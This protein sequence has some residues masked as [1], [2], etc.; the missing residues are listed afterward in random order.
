MHQLIVLESNPKENEQ[1]PTEIDGLAVDIPQYDVRYVVNSLESKHVMKYKVFVE[2]KNKEQKRFIQDNSPKKIKHEINAELAE[3][4][5]RNLA[6]RVQ[7][8]PDPYYYYDPIS[9]TINAKRSLKKAKKIH[10]KFKQQ[11]L[12]KE[13]K[14][15]EQVSPTLAAIPLVGNYYGFHLATAVQKKSADLLGTYKG[16][17]DELNGL[18][19]LLHVPEK[20]EKEVMENN[21]D[22]D[23]EDNANEETDKDYEDEDNKENQKNKNDVIEEFES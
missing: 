19:Q 12:N 13:E 23:D 15:D 20:K 16:L 21:N 11:F 4:I 1:D 3:I 14:I 8:I 18:L 5:A 9:L 10:Q 6:K 2:A 17:N 7:R 22:Q